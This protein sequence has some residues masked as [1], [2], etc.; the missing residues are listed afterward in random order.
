MSL[1]IWMMQRSLGDVHFYRKFICN[2]TS[3]AAPL[4]HLTSHPP[5]VS[6][7]FCWPVQIT[8]LIVKKSVKTHDV[9]LWIILIYYHISWYFTTNLHAMLNEWKIWF[10]LPLTHQVSHSLSN[11]IFLCPMITLY[12]FPWKCSWDY[13]MNCR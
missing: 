4:H 9:T 12:M 3:V 7:H 1:S 10:K 11:V 13:L 6:C 5:L 2:Y 8:S